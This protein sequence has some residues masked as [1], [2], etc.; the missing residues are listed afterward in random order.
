MSLM[1]L[2][3]VGVSPGAG[4]SQ[5]VSVKC[6]SLSGDGWT[7]FHELLI[8][9]FVVHPGREGASLGFLTWRSWGGSCK[10]FEVETVKPHNIASA[11]FQWLHQVGLAH[12][13]RR[14]TSS[15]LRRRVAKSLYRGICFQE[16][17][18]SMKPFFQ[19]SYQRGFTLIYPYVYR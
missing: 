19:T 6:L 10:A 18:E 17:E 5:M 3:S 2:L 8:S 7:F 13:K 16:R 4:W 15:A 11:A 12:I 1:W 9:L 14:E